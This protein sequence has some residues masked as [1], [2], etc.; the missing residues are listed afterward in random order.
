MSFVE[1]KSN[2]LY[3]KSTTEY[4]VSLNQTTVWHGIK[5]QSIKNPLLGRTLRYVRKLTYELRLS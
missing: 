1:I 2:I 4:S 5:S 3:Y